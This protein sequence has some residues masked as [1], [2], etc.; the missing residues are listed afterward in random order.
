MVCCDDRNTQLTFE[1]LSLAAILATPLRELPTALLRI[2]SLSLDG[3]DALRIGPVT[4]WMEPG[5][6]F[7]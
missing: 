2:G 1:F 4:V 7:T 3:V 6:C 5:C